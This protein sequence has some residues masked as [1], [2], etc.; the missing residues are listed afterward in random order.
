[1]YGVIQQKQDNPQLV[2]PEASFDYFKVSHYFK[3]YYE[4]PIL[5]N[6]RGRRGKR[7]GSPPPQE[8]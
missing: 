2:D 1:M 5:V 8:C 7:E 3:A 4:V 6:K